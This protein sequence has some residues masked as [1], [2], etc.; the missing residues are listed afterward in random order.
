MSALSQLRRLFISPRQKIGGL[1]IRELSC[2]CPVNNAQKK[3]EIF[4]EKEVQTLLKELTGLN[5]EKIFRVRKMGQSVQKPVYQFMTEEEIQE[6]QNEIRKKAEDKLQMP[7]V[8]EERNPSG[9]VLE[10]DPD[11]IGFDTCKYVFTDISFGVSDRSRIAVVRDPDGT[12]RTADW[13]EQDRLNQTYYPRNG[14]RHYV[15]AMFQHENLQ[16]LLGPNKYEVILDKNCLQFEPD[17][18][19]YIQTAHAVYDHVNENNNFECLH[20]TRHYGPML[21]HLAWTKQLDECII[22]LIRKDELGD[23]AKAVALYLIIH[24]DCK[25]NSVEEVELGPED[26]IRLYAEMESNKSAKVVMALERL[27]ETK[28]A[29]KNTKDGILESQGANS[30]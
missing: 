21:F 5:Y 7:P 20:S 17:H 29:S 18:P 23:A 26:M 2:T 3:D 13:E 25:M 27:N 6:A 24:P 14:R 1:A 19:L 16:S 8:M 4:F 30:A 22:H 10:T 12:L 9:R 28:S 15:P 11:L